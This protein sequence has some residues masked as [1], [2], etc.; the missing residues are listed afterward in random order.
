MLPNRFSFGDIETRRPSNRP[1]WLTGYVLLG[2][3]IFM[4]AVLQLVA[5]DL[6]RRYYAAFIHLRY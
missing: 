1:A 5:P 6:L 4:A 3:I 2:I